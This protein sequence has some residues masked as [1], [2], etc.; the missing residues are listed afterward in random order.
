MTFSLTRRQALASSA[1]H[2]PWPA[3]EVTPPASQRT[4]ISH[5]VISKLRPFLL[6]AAK[7]KTPKVSSA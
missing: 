7:L 1:T 5:W 2:Q 6:A 3:R 4:A